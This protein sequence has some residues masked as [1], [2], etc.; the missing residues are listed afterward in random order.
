MAY[1]SPFRDIY[2]RQFQQSPYEQYG[3]YKRPTETRAWYQLSPIEKQQELIK[4]Q[5]KLAGLP[6]LPPERKS[7]KDAFKPMLNTL[8]F[9]SGMLNVPS[10][11]ISGAVKQLVDGAPGFDTQEYFKDVFG[12]KEQV[13]WRDVISLLAERD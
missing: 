7:L 9:V 3:A 5:E 6:P 1:E 4:Q 2:A 13:G 8:Q 11:A 12:F 10:A